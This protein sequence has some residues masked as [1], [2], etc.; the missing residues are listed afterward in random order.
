LECAPL[1]YDKTGRKS[2]IPSDFGKP[3]NMLDWR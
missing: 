2:I 1:F 3:E